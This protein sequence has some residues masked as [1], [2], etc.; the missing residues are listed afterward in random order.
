MNLMLACLAFPPWIKHRHGINRYLFREAIAGYVPEA[1]RQRNDKS[2]STIPHT[3]YSLIRDKDLILDFI[4]SCSGIPALHEIFD[5]S[6]FPSWYEKLVEWPS[7][8]MNFL[9]PGAFYDYLMIMMY[10]KSNVK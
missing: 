7:E 2:G 9:M 10:F 4:R 8:E 5:F 1:I 3:Y 6:R